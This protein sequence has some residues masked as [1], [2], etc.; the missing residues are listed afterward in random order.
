MVPVYVVTGFLGAGKSSFIRDTLGRREWQDVTA[1]TVQFETGAEKLPD[2][3]ENVAIPVKMLERD[4]AGVVNTLS[5]RISAGLERQ[6]RPID[7]IWIEWNGV[8]SYNRLL[9]LLL[10]PPLRELCSVKRVI[11]VADAGALE[12]LLGRTGIA[13]PEQ[14]AASDLVM[15]REAESAGAFRRARRL[16][17]SINPGVAVYNGPADRFYMQI[18]TRR[19]SP[20]SAFFVI[21]AAAA[22][23]YIIAIPPLEDMGVPASKTVNIFLGVILQSAPFLLIGVLLSSAIEIFVTRSAIER[24]FPK[25]AVAGMLAAVFAGFLLPV[26]DCA[27]IPIFRSLVRKG[28]PLYAAVTFMAAAPVINPVVMLSTYYAFNGDVR[29]VAARVLLGITSAAV[30]GLTFAARRPRENVLSGGA[31]DALMCGC[32]YFE[33][34]GSVTTFRGKYELFLSHAQAEFW[35]VGKYLVIGTFVSAALQSAGLGLFAQA[36]SGMGLAASIAAMM[37]ISFVLSLCSSSDAVVARSFSAQF[38]PA[39]LMGF[40]IFGP[41]ADIKNVMML[42]SGF[43]KRFIARFAATAFAVCFAAVFIYYSLRGIT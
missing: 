40:L 6:M 27:S 37:A 26:C 42:S 4:F 11:H 28:I 1:L 25:S 38:P 16:I 7:E 13:L 35:N 20:F 19:Q 30:T 8:V 39:A 36:S 3:A 5:E 18:Y 2:G 31:I 23:L 33:D 29:I 22:L 15:V 41:M 14:I 9:E 17:R 43:T 34:V 21:I 24:R 32:G 12:N 10:S